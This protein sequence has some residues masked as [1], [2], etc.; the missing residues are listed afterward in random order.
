M[1]AWPHRDRDGLYESVPETCY[2]NELQKVLGVANP[3]V[4]SYSYGLYCRGNEAERV[5]MA[6]ITGIEFSILPLG[7]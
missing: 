5:M 6:Q 2:S 7:A 4:F 3:L 1:F